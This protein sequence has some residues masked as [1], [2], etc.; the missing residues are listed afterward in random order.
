MYKIEFENEGEAEEIAR[1]MWKNIR[2]ICHPHI[3]DELNIDE[4]IENLK[5]N[6]HIK[7]S[8]LEKAK[9]KWEAGSHCSSQQSQNYIT[10]LKREIRRL[11]K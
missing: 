9:K 10:E 2:I 3:S 8:E 1:I 11:K 4:T 7:R 5:R 6:G